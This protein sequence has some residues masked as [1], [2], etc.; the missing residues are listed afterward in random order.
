M[1][2]KNKYNKEISPNLMKEF[3]YKSVMQI[4][5]IEKIVINAGVGDA[6][7]DSKNIDLA[8]NELY[9][10]TGQKPIKTKAKKSIATYKVREGQEIGVKVTLRNA[11]MWNFLEKLI[12][13]AIPRIRDFRGISNKSFDGRGNFTMGIKEQII[14]PEIHFD[15]IKKLR[16][17]DVTIVTSAE[18][19]EEAFSLLKQIGIPFVKTK[20]KQ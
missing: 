13:V 7:Q 15:D 4:P 10:I 1:I 18:T 9:K 5:K 11:T 20:E 17:F 6:S 16:G 14:F 19:N 2:L 3:S 12:N 8:F